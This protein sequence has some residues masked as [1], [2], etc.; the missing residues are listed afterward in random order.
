VVVGGDVVVVE[1][2]DRSFVRNHV[3]AI[4]NNVIHR[5]RRFTAG[6]FVFICHPKKTQMTRQMGWFDMTSMSGWVRL[7]SPTGGRCC[8]WEGK[9]S[10]AGPPLSY[11][12]GG[13]LMER[14]DRQDHIRPWF[15]F[16]SPSGK[17]PYTQH[18][19]PET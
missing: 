1:G 15:S 17:Q 13:A 9:S 16:F 2:N 6:G 19:E 5:D 8:C 10:P 18:Q 7:E 14:N 4:N 3:C 11:G 12:G